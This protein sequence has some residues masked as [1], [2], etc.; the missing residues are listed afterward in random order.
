MNVQPVH[1]APHHTGHLPLCGTRHINDGGKHQLVMCTVDRD[2]T[3]CFKC[4]DQYEER[5]ATPEQ[6]EA[7]AQV[8]DEIDA[9]FEE[10]KHRAAFEDGKRITLH[11]MEHMLADMPWWQVRRRF[12]HRRAMSALRTFRFGDVVK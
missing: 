1:F 2:M 5:A 4:I 9:L 8:R 12:R 3:T 11:V 6:I 10:L 7:L